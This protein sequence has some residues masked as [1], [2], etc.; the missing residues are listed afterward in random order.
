MVVSAHASRLKSASHAAVMAFSAASASALFPFLLSGFCSRILWDRGNNVF[1][2]HVDDAPDDV[3]TAA[4]VTCAWEVSS[5]CS[6]SSLTAFLTMW[7]SSESELTPFLRASL[8]V[9]GTSSHAEDDASP[10]PSVAEVN[11][12]MS[13]SAESFLLLQ[14]LEA[15]STLSPPL[16]YCCPACG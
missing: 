4:E 13:S 16:P 9:S 10:S 12:R 3:V 15:M 11:S 1:D 14:A 5:R 8:L 7:S 2:C 6:A